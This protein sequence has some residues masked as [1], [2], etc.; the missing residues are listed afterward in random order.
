MKKISPKQYAISLYESIKDSHGEELTQR[1]RNFLLVIKKRKDLKNLNKI[2]Q[3][4]VKVYQI[5]E[6][7]LSAEVTASHPL[8]HK[9]NEEIIHWLKTETKRNPEL[10]EKVDAEILGGVI[11]KYED[12]IIDASLKNRLNKLK[13]N[14]IK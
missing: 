12:T 8:N 1:I 7:I 5:S 6:G 4:F 11:I 13:E 10:T 2:Y 14:L 3:A 9:V